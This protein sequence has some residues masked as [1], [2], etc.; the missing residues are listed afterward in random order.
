MPNVYRTEKP[1]STTQN[2]KFFFL[3]ALQLFVTSNG[4]KSFTSLRFA[5]D[6]KRIVAN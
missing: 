2:E 4:N 5:N 1:F 3:I 6:Q